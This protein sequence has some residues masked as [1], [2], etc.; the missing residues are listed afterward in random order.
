MK[1]NRIFD[2]LCGHFPLELA[3]QYDNPGFLVG[4]KN[5]EISKA[6]ITLDCDF[7]AI[8]KARENGCELIITHHPV[9]FSPIKN[10]LSDSVVYELIRNEISVIS[11]HTNLD[12]AAGGVNDRLCEKIGL[13]NVECTGA[14]D[15]FPLRMGTC[16]EMSADS[17]AE[18]LKKRLGGGV[19]Y[20]KCDKPIK[21]VLVCSGSG[22]EFLS[23]AVRLGCD[24]LVTGDVKHN[25]FIDA[26]NLALSLFD[27]GHFATEDVIIDPLANLLRNEFPSLQ[28]IT[29]HFSAIK[30][31]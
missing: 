13:E 15:G 5:A 7:T 2:F 29:S 16:P 17:F 9:I 20:A 1:A 25:F 12:A 8:K 10:V 11:M 28:F 27:A 4:D 14:Q 30:T 23:D 24:A 22:G 19:K 26:G 18:L 6:L 3:A 21:K 31:I